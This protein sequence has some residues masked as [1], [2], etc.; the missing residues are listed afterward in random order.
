[1]DLGVGS[2]VFSQGLVGAIPYVKDP[3]YAQAPVLGKLIG[4]GKKCLPILILG[5]I[6]VALVKGTDYPEHVSEY[7]VHWNFFIT[8]GLLPLASILMHPLLETHSIS[9]L[10]LGIT[11]GV[12]RCFWE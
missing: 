10:G 4:T 11:L 8:L 7:G 2:F 3:G 6:R 12:Y 5:L 9:L 1:M